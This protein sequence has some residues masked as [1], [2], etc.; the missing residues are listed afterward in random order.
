MNLS[1]NNNNSVG[2]DLKFNMNNELKK[3]ENVMG[4]S[5]NGLTSEKKKILFE[6]SGSDAAT[7]SSC[8]SHLK[9]KRYRRNNDQ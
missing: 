2:K 5:L 7:A 6:C 1:G 9:K 8:K 3:F 4:A